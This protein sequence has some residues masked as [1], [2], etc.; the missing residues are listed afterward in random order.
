MVTIQA[1][2]CSTLAE[3]CAK[4]RYFYDDMIQM[5]EDA[6]KK[7]LRPVVLEPLDA[8][9]YRLSEEDNW[10]KESLQKCINDICAKFDINMAKIAQ[11]LRVAV[12]GSSMSPAIDITL[13]LL[14]K[15]RTLARLKDALARIRERIAL[16]S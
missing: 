14:G 16:S 9:Y 2:R 7:Y 11:P 12:T 15:Q 3:I 5:D 13:T 6:A 10:E 1:E 8:L 4:S